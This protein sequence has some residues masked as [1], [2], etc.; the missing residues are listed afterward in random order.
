MEPKE[1]EIDSTEDKNTVNFILYTHSLYGHSECSDNSFHYIIQSCYT[2]LTFGLGVRV[3]TSFLYTFVEK[4][5]E[6][7]S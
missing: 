5:K 4:I 6:I 2:L 1:A 7:K 3:I